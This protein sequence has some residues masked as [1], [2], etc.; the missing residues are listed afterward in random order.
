L[1]FERVFFTRST[2]HALQSGRTHPY[3]CSPFGC[4]ARLPKAGQWPKLCNT[5][6]TQHVFPRFRSPEP[7]EIECM[8]AEQLAI[9]S[10]ATQAP[11]QRLA[12]LLCLL[13]LNWFK[14]PMTWAC[15]TRSN[16]NTG[17]TDLS[18]TLCMPYRWTMAFTAAVS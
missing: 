16:T 14:G 3:P 5:L 12:I 2:M 18:S 10:P 13:A 6:F 1:D 17:F 4:N 15:N 7:T 8:R 9:S 11:F